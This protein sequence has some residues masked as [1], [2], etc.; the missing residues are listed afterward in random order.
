MNF[1]TIDFET[2]KY[3]RES[4]CAVGLVKFEKGRPVDTGTLNAILSEQ[5]ETTK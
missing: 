4:A 2:A 5:K 3:S 1:V